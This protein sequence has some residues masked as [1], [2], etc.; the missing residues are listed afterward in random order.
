M[1]GGLNRDDGYQLY[2]QANGARRK[3]LGVPSVPRSCLGIGRVRTG[4]GTRRQFWPLG[5]IPIEQR[6]E[7]AA[8]VVQ[9]LPCVLPAKWP[10]GTRLPDGDCLIEKALGISAHRAP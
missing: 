7:E 1:P 4:G 3:G 6:L 9:D 5:H 10:F 2:Q 8:H